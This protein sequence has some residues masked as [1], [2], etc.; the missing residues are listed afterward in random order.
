MNYTIKEIAKE[1]GVSKTTVSLVINGKA[2][3]NRINPETEKKILDIIE[4][5]GFAPNKLARSFRTNKSETIGLILPDVR[6]PFFSSL[7]Y[8]FE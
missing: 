1:A 4:K 5:S 2:R 6:N 8:A 3:A 7:S